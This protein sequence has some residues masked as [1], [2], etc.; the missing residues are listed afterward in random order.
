MDEINTLKKSITFVSDKIDSLIADLD[1]VSRD[2]CILHSSHS[3]QCTQYLHAG[4]NI[5]QHP[6]EF[7]AKA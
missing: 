6:N 5:R 3:A 4:D 7:R 1:T 2:Y